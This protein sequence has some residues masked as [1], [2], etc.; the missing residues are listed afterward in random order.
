M[1]CC[2]FLRANLVVQAAKIVLL[3][4][5]DTCILPEPSLDLLPR[6]FPASILV[7]LPENRIYVLLGHI[8]KPKRPHCSSKFA[9]I[10]HAITIFIPSPKYFANPGY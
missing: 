7:K 3:L 2:S 9:L 10:H 5:N 4:H 6:D 1:K 8:R